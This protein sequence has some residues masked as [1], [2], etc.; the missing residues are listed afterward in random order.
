MIKRIYKYISLH[1]LLIQ[2]TALAL[3]VTTIILSFFALHGMSKQKKELYANLN[4]RVEA[5]SSWL[6]TALVQPLYNL[7]YDTVAGLCN[8]LIAL[9]GIV[10]IS[11][12]ANYKTMVFAT[13]NA[14]ELLQ[15]K[16]H[17]LSV[18]KKITYHD[19]EIGQV[20]VLASSLY[21][22]EQIRAMAFDL[23]LQIFILDCCLV[24]A[25]ILLLTQKFIFPLKQLQFAAEKIALGDLHHS[26][27]I[28]SRNELGYLAADL[29]TMRRTLKGKIADLENEIAMRSVAEEEREL[30]VSYIDNII[31]SMPSLLISLDADLK[32]TQW[33]KSAET[34]SGVASSNAKGNAIESVLP[35]FPIDKN[36]IHRAI[37]LKE[38]VHFTLHVAIEGQD[39]EQVEVTIF[40]LVC[41]GEDGAVIRIDNVTEQHRMR[42]ELT[43]TRKLDAIGQL[44]GGVAHDFNNMLAGIIGGAELLSLYYKEDAKAKEYVDM[45]I[46]SGKRAGELTHKLLAFARKGKIESTPIDVA[47]AIQDAVSILNHTLD[48]R[49]S[50]HMNIDA[51]HTYII[52]DLT[53]IQ[54]ALIN[55]GVNAGHAMPEGGDIEINLTEIR[56][57]EAYCQES[58]FEITEGQYLDM[59]VRD[60]GK[61]IPKDNLN[62][63][64]EPFFTTKE[65]GEGSGLGLAAVYGAVQEH[66]GAITVYSKVGAGTSFHL[67]LPVADK[68]QQIFIE[69][70]D[71]IVYGQGTVLVIDDEQVISVTARSILEALGYKVVLAHNGKE[72]IEKYKEHA[73]DIDVVIIDMIMPEMNG[74]ECFFAIKAIND[75]VKVLLASGLS[76]KPDL[77]ELTTNG[78]NGF[79]QKPYTTVQL[80]KA[81]SAL[82]N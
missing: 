22:K 49:I 63:I 73:E 48:K 28:K 70:E 52:G 41:T 1:G 33:N 81:L 11:V 80:S 75:K 5:N 62:R 32:V 34:I 19:L 27:E 67:Y 53:L 21:L 30:A 40:P 20:S 51:E 36:E 8:S 43:H 9:P 58:P 35:Q 65:A 10:Q 50:I 56:L 60:S 38:V 37:N 71:A 2:V 29:E 46:Q 61:G 69:K 76:I 47:K 66:G 82:L 23:F 42:T 6:A 79:I 31:N 78:L 18:D 17:V 45:I 13:Q 25:I 57:D 64:F 44:A 26:I 39:I 68:E 77:E 59:E 74:K 24:S 72:G 4:S 14:P 16:E 7:D 3:I 15:A 55:L 12:D 54:N